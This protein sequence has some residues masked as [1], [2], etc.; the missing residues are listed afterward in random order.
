MRVEVKVGSKWGI[1]WWLFVCGF[2]R[3]KSQERPDGCGVVKFGSVKMAR[4]EV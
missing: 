3:R 1:G 2:R 4:V